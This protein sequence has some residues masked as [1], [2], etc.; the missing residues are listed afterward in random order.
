MIIKIHFIASKG[1]NHIST[2]TNYYNEKLKLPVG[3]LSTG[4]AEV[5]VRRT[6]EFFQ[7]FVLQLHKL[8][9]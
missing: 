5:R 6:P 7:A 9:L 2:T 4:I 8:S 3:L 1:W